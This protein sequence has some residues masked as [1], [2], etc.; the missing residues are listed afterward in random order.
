MMNSGKNG[1]ARIFL[2]SKETLGD[3]IRTGTSV[4]MTFFRLIFVEIH[5]WKDL[6]ILSNMGDV[7]DH[8]FIT[9]AKGL[10]GWVGLE[11]DQFC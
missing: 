8:N 10:G 4:K 6:G 7:W 5:M 1:Y 2:H 11:N 9:S 3:S